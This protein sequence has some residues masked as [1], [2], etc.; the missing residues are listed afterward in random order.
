MIL[1][2]RDLRAG[3]MFLP[4]EDYDDRDA[5][6]VVATGI[7]RDEPAFV[8]ELGIEVVTSRG[9]VRQWWG[10]PDRRY[11]EDELIGRIES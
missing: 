10:P 9:A 5:Y 2:W 3:D 11:F 7:K 4:G 1:R 8:G 6:V